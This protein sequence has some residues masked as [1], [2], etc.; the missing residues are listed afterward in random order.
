MG[1]VAYRLNLPPTSKIH[2]VVHV[3]LLKHEVG[4]EVPVNTQLP[5]PNTVLQAEHSPD[6]VID[7]KLVRVD[8]TFG[9]HV[10][11]KW[12]DLP[13]DLATWEDPIKLQQRYPTTLPW[14]QGGPRRG[15]CHD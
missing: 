12:S 4:A 5:P 11:I 13:A 1:A 15:E 3:S 2:P 6:G 8:G 14:G 7:K 9:P 10:L